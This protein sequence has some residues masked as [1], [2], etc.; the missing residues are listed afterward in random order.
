MI[1]LID[2]DDLGSSTAARRHAGPDPIVDIAVDDAG[3]TDAIPGVEDLTRLAAEEALAVAGDRYRLAVSV[4]LG[5]DQAVRR[6]NQSWRG[7]DKATNVLSFPALDIIAGQEL[8][9]EAGH[10]EDEPVALG[11]IIVARQT[12]LD[13]AAAENKKPGNHLSHLIVHGVLHL[14]GYDHM[15]EDEAMRM[16]TLECELLGRLGIADP[17]R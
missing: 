12:V 9:P 10:P 2:A 7:I 3:W 16:E 13:E 11:D 6:L 4:V 14:L 5:D 8:E 1:E 17:Y 15:D